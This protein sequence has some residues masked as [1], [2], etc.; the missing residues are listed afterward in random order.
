MAFVSTMI[1]AALRMTGEKARGAT[2]DAN[3]LVECLAELNTM[4]E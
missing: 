4:M 1:L 3:E 2:L